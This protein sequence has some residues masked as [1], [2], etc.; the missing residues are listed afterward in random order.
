MERLALWASLELIPNLFFVL[1]STFP[2]EQTF[3][4]RWTPLERSQHNVVRRKPHVGWA[5]VRSRIVEIDLRMSL[6]PF[7]GAFVKF[8]LYLALAF[9]VSLPMLH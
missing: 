8:M 1:T 4:T 3:I 7:F 9:A 6:M 2:L 5:L